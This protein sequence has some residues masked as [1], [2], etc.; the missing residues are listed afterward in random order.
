VG[1]S[2][3][4]LSRPSQAAGQ[5]SLFPNFPF[6]FFLSPSPS[7]DARLDRSVPSVP[8]VS[9]APC[10]TP[11]LPSPIKTYLL[12]RQT[13]L[14]CSVNISRPR[15]SFLRDGSSRNRNKIARRF[16]P[17][18]SVRLHD[19]RKAPKAL[20]L[21]R[22]SRCRPPDRPRRLRQ[23]RLI[24]LDRPLHRKEDRLVRLPSLRE[25]R[26][27]GVCC[28]TGWFILP[29]I[30]RTSHL[31]GG[32]DQK[33]HPALPKPRAPSFVRRG[34]FQGSNR[35][36]LTNATDVC[37]IDTCVVQRH[38]ARILENQEIKQDL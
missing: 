36:F 18:V 1:N 4:L 21:S 24:P 32:Q 31:S 27:V 33:N 35:F 5:Q 7:A 20:N 37:I 30:S 29:L 12:F 38:S 10:A 6:Y 2:P 14:P 28:V 3:G 11:E 26:G 15:L 13:R 8:F 22:C 23:K 34:A 9:L 17:D 19:A 25:E 16:P